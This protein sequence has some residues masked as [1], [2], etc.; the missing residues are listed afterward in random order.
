[1]NWK[2]ELDIAILEGMRDRMGDKI[3]IIGMGAVLPDAMDLSAY[4]SNILAAKDSIKDISD[5]YWQIEDF[6]DPDP[7]ARDKSYGFKAGE[8]S[9]V[10]FDA[11][12]FGIPPKV[13]ESIS[14]EQ[15]Y[16]LV[17]AKQ[18]LLDADLIGNQA[19]AFDREKAGVIMAATVGKSAFALSRRQDI[20]Q[21]KIILKNSGLPEHMIER[22][23]ERML[24]AEIEWN[25]NSE[26]GFLAN[27]VAG[28]IANRFDLHGTNCAVDA[29]CA[30]S[31]A[32]LKMAIHE[33]QSGDCDVVLA[34]GV[35]LD[36]TSTAFI[37]F[38]KTPAISKTNIS[39]PF[40]A[41]ADGMILGDGV[42]MMVLKRLADAKRDNDR[43]YAVIEAMGSSGD[44]R[45]TSIFA[46]NREGQLRALGRAYAKT[47]LNPNTISLIEAH[48]TGTF[49]G[50]ATEISALTQFFKEYNVNKNSIAIGSVKSQIGHSRLTAGMSS[51]IKTAL[52][53]YHRTLPP[54]INVKV[55]RPDLLASPFYTLATPQPWLTDR[56]HPI[57]R[58]GVSSFGFGGTNFHVIMEEYREGSDSK[59]RRAHQIPVGICL[60]AATREELLALCKLTFEQIGTN[61]WAYQQLLDDQKELKVIKDDWPRVGFVAQ[62]RES[63]KEK[64]QKVIQV[65]Q[66]NPTVKEITQVKEGIY[67]REGAIL[68]NGKVVALFSG[69]G[70]QYLGMFSE[71]ARDYPEMTSFLSFVEEQLEA[72]G[73]RSIN[74][75]LYGA[76]NKMPHQDAEE[77]LNN[78]KY[79]QPILAA[80]CGGLYEVLKNRGFKED[81]I[82]GHSFGELTGLWAGGA[83]DAKAFVKL[84]AFRGKLMSEGSNNTGMISITADVSSCKKWLKDYRNLYI[85]NEN[86]LTQTVVSGD[87][88]EIKELERKLRELNI[89][90]V[91]L[92]VSQGFHSPYM[93][94]A[95]KHFTAFI[96]QEKFSALKKTL[97]SGADGKP[98]KKRGDLVKSTFGKQIEASVRFAKCIEDAYENGGRVFVEIG[99]GRILTNLT[100]RIL[101]GKEHY[102]VAINGASKH[103]SANEQ[104]EEAL[105]LLRVLGMELA[106]D[107]Y[108]KTTA[109]LYKDEKPKSA[110]EINPMGY[111]TPEKEEI[112][113]QAI[114]LEELPYQLLTENEAGG[115]EK[116]YAEVLDQPDRLEEIDD[117]AQVNYQLEDIYNQEGELVMA[118]STMEAVLGLQKTNTKALEEYLASQEKQMDVFKDLFKEA[119]HSGAT[120]NV[121]RF[122]EIFQ[123]NSLR[124]FETYMGRQQVIIGG[125]DSSSAHREDASA[126]ATSA[127]M[128]VPL[129]S[130]E[131]E[132]KNVAKTEIY[133]ESASVP[134]VVALQDVTVQKTPTQQASMPLMP[135]SNGNGIDISSFDPVQLM[136]GVISEKS[137]YPE[138]LIDAEMNIEADLG[139]DSIKRIEIF[140]EIGKQM[141]GEIN[142]EDVEAISMLH[143][144]QEI[145]DYIR[146]K[147]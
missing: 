106:G 70:S 87:M 31:M 99:P 17:V 145:G 120:D 14:V 78:T 5:T 42:A 66:E 19:K 102:T 28:R 131:I 59:W 15:L 86:S 8:V 61:E 9:P 56:N 94:E 63:A 53:L 37:S 114:E 55:D 95:S 43:I 136:I 140:A 85:A 121:V 6:Y 20:P 22:I 127:S 27:V 48:G 115:A 7:T 47:D 119:S 126:V 54:T 117:E 108:R 128:L 75:I 29:A 92:K 112:I 132:R 2:E 130:P 124:A 142:Q 77:A 103:Q 16:A 110:Y 116:V 18:A 147:V 65:L 144:I 24:A 104:L 80:V 129:R 141:P 1:M 139:I 67:F 71:I 26:P 30:S 138:E 23:V 113:K 4:W 125:A 10:L 100:N 88:T 107:L 133:E 64:L 51:L 83:I 50:D 91:M 96:A 111:V 21:M 137:G 79:T 89:S 13:M 76:G 82:I 146:K 36:L 135:D 33:L 44:G 74:D 68:P 73:L 134:R 143:T 72:K 35:N 69:Q 58:A 109:E 62:D 38:C 81:A 123:N 41:D 46:P 32:A 57:R 39:R 97:Y 12:G 93:V 118:K 25:E 34:G 49:V 90:S 11:I 52:A 3:A 122:I 60:D 98:Y 45:A 84:A 101:V 105:V 40:D